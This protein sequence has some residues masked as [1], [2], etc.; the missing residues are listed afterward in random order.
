MYSPLPII[1]FFDQIIYPNNLT[2]APPIG[3]AKVVGCSAK[4]ATTTYSLEALLLL[5]L[6]IRGALVLLRRF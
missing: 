3:C 5:L 4:G 6:Y 1:C 2:S